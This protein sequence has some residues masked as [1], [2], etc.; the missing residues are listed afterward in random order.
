MTPL[1]Q[2]I[3]E[4]KEVTYLDADPA[5][6]EAFA[7]WHWP[8]A[9][10]PSGYLPALDRDL[11]APEFSDFL[12]VCRVDLPDEIA[13]MIAWCMV[14][15]RGAI[16][17]QYRHL[18]PDRSPITYPLEPKAIATTPIPLHPAAEATYAALDDDTR[19]TGALIWT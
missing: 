14:A 1:W 3:T 19:T 7:K 13:S 2:R 5:V 10:V 6:A 12:L 4:R 9:T 15:T 11:I 18:P 17:G 8:T 16:E